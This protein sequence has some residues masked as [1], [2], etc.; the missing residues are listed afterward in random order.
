MTRPG[1][2][3]LLS[4]VHF[5]EASQMGESVNLVH[6]PTPTTSWAL[7]ALMLALAYFPH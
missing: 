7:F 5:K 3:Y 1:S 4:Q 6:P 2:F